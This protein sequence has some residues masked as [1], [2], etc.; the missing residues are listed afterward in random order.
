MVTIRM[1]VP[2]MFPAQLIKFCLVG[3]INTGVDFAAFTLLALWGVPLSATQCLAYT[4]G[5]VNSFLLNR[6]WTFKQYSRDSGQ[7]IR[8]FLLNL[9]TL[10][11]TYG[12]LAVLHEKL[13]I[14]L[15]MSKVFI[16]GIGL[17][18]N[19]F[20]SRRWVFQSAKKFLPGAE[21]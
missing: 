21:H 2:K 20:G 3:V 9:F 16:T 13:G 19:F 5:V 17:V 1:K 12:L 4:C 8:F 6:K 7:L 18:I 11:V 10:T 15:V 14:S